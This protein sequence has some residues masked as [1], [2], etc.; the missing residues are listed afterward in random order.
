MTRKSSSAFH[1]DG[2]LFGALQPGEC[3]SHEPRARIIHDL[4]HEITHLTWPKPFA[5]AALMDLKAAGKIREV[6]LTNFDT[7]HMKVCSCGAYI[8]EAAAA[9]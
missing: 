7:E 2:V 4:R 5:G 8:H 3:V 1:A 9:K 6:A